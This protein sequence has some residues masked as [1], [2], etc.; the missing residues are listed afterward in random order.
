MIKR[1]LLKPQSVT[2]WQLQIKY[3]AAPH[4]LVGICMVVAQSSSAL[5]CRVYKA[6]KLPERMSY[7][8]LY[9]TFLQ[10]ALR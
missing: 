2:K 6:N 9:A 7:G 8:I 3:S 10:T 5:V 4:N 1:Q